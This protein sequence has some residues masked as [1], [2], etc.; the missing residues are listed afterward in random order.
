MHAYGGHGFHLCVCVYARRLPSLKLI[1]GREVGLEE[2]DRA[3]LI[4]AS[5][6]RPSQQGGYQGYAHDQR[7]NSTKAPLKPFTLP[8]ALALP[9]A[10]SP[11]SS[12]TP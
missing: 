12:P 9:L 1:D 10:P 11:T 5:D 3:E 8:L 2:R 7:S 6:L 4:F